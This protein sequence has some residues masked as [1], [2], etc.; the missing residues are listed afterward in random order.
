MFLWATH[1]ANSYPPNRYSPSGRAPG[2]QGARRERQQCFTRRQHL[3]S[4]WSQESTGVCENAKAEEDLPYPLLR[5]GHLLHGVL[6]HLSQ[7]FQFQVCVIVGRRKGREK[8]CK[9]GKG[10]IGERKKERMRNKGGDLGRETE[11]D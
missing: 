3:P 4:G 1:V 2:V 11:A 9:E 5:V 6:R 7:L 8:I 10:R